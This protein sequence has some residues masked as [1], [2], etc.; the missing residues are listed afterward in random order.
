MDAS[1]AKA[2]PLDFLSF[3]HLFF[4]FFFL[5]ILSRKTRS[6]KDVHVS[7]ALP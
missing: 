3:P 1:L 6:F 5:L 4:S 7:L 2:V